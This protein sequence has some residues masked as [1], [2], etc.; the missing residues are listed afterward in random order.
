MAEK[1]KRR[2]KKISQPVNPNANLP[3]SGLDFKTPPKP[4]TAS[5]DAA[6]V[7]SAGA[8]QKDQE[9]RTQA[10]KLLDSQRES[11]AMLTAVKEAIDRLPDMR[12]SL[13]EK[14]Y[15]YGDNMI[16]SG[17]IL[18][19]LEAEGTN[20]LENMAQDLDNLGSGEFIVSLEGGADQYQQC[21][22]SIE[23]VVS[24]TKHLP[25]KVSS[26]LSSAN[27]MGTLRTFDMK[28]LKAARELLAAGQESRVE[29]SFRKIVQDEAED[30]RRFSLR[31]Y[32]VPEDWTGGGGLSFQDG[33]G[34]TSVE[35]KRDRL[36][37]WNS[38]E[39]MVRQDPWEGMENSPVASCI[40][41]HLV[42][43]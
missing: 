39:T 9:T 14:G 3:P 25:E 19:K 28:S 1:R 2:S 20:M 18:Q 36:V 26:G 37:V 17:D 32:T 41:L 43:N 15:W 22:R 34:V 42:K 10:Q 11:V 38:C 24:A 4:P 33:D 7:A 27:C 5:V 35:A 40:D 23:W 16:D 30:L 21:P 13:A 12:D 31:Y 8:I 6:Q 29:R